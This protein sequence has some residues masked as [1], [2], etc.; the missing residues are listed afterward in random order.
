MIHFCYKLLSIVNTK[1]GCCDLRYGST[2]VQCLALML[3][4]QHTPGLQIT[5]FKIATL[6]EVVSVLYDHATEKRKDGSG[7]QCRP[8]SSYMLLLRELLRLR[9]MLS[10]VRVELYAYAKR[11]MEHI[12]SKRQD[13]SQGNSLEENSESSPICACSPDLKII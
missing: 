4:R 2:I 10:V 7:N 6:Q 1:Q 13:G 12:A 9:G 11:V 8:T 3:R 5:E